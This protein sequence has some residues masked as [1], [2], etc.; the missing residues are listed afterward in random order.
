MFPW[1]EQQDLEGL[2]KC[3][4]PVWQVKYDMV[5]LQEENTHQQ[6]VYPQ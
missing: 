4:D 6:S 3:V 2:I 1:I 5:V